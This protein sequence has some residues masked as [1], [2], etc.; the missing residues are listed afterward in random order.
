MRFR[1]FGIMYLQIP[2][3]ILLYIILFSS[4]AI[5]TWRPDSFLHTTSNPFHNLTKWEL[6]FKVVANGE[7]YREDGGH[8]RI[9][10]KANILKSM[11]IHG[12][13]R[14]LGIYE[15]GVDVVNA[16]QTMQLYGSNS[17]EK[18]NGQ[19]FNFQV[20]KYGDGRIRS[21]YL[22]QFIVSVQMQD[23]IDGNYILNVSSSLSDCARLRT[24]GDWADKTRWQESSVPISSDSV[25]FPIGS[26]VINLSVNLRIDSVTVNDATLVSHNSRCP[27]GWSISNIE[28]PSYKCY[29]LFENAT[30]FEDASTQCR[31][32]GL[33]SIDS[34]LVLI[35]SYAELDMMKGLCRGNSSDVA[36]ITGCWIGLR[37]LDGDRKF[38]W[39]E[40]ALRKKNLQLLVVEEMTSTSFTFYDWKRNGFD[41]RTVSEGY[42][43]G[44][45]KCAYLRSWQEDPLIQE[46]GSIDDI[47]CNLQKA[48]ICQS[49]ALTTKFLVEAQTVKLNGGEFVGGSMSVSSSATISKFRFKSSSSLILKDTSGKGSSLNRIDSLE[50]LDGSKLSSY[51]DLTLSGKAFIG[52]PVRS[53]MQSL[54]Y[55]AADSTLKI[56]VSAIVNARVDV[57]GTLNVL[58]NAQITLNQGGELSQSTLSLPSATST[59]ALGG[60]AS[61]LS[62]YDAYD[63]MLAHRGPVVGEYYR[64][65]KNVG[66]DKVSLIT[67]EKSSPM[68]GVYKLAVTGKDYV[69]KQEV[70]QTTL[71]IDYHATQD[72]LAFALEKLSLISSRGGVTVRRVGYADDPLFSYGYKHRIELDATPSW[73]FPLGS[74]AFNFSCYGA[75]NC[76]CAESIVPM[77]DSTGA[78]KCPYIK[79]PLPGYYDHANTENSGEVCILPPLITISKIS[80][81][82][83]VKTSG[84]GIISV[85]AGVHRLPPDCTV[86]IKA[87]GGRA[88]V[89]ANIITWKSLNISAVGKLVVAGTGWLAWDSSSMLYLPEWTDQRAVSAL[90]NA[91]PAQMSVTDFSVGGYSSF[92]ISCPSTNVSVTNGNW[93]GGILRGRGTIYFSS[94]LIAS[95]GWKSLQDYILLFIKPSANL[96]W[97]GGNISIANGAYVIVEG[98]FNVK[99]NDQNVIMYFGQSQLMDIPKA[100]SDVHP[101]LDGM[102]QMYPARNWNGYYDQSLAP[103]I[104]GGWY[105]NPEC[106]PHCLDTSQILVRKNA[107]IICKDSVSATFF[108]PVN[109]IDNTK[110]KIGKNS[111]VSL[112]SGGTCDM[113]VIINIDTGTN[114]FLTGGQFRM[115][116]T[117][118]I[119]GSGELTS[120]AGEHTLAQN[121]NAHIT[122][123]GGTLIWPN[124]GGVNKTIYFHGG[125]LLEKTGSLQVR[126]WSTSIIV[127]KVV[128]FRDQCKIQFPVIGIAAQPSMSDRFDAPDDSPR[129]KLVAV[130]MLKFFGGTL[131]GKADFISRDKLYLGGQ[132]KY[133]MSMAKLINYGL[134]VWDTGNIITEN[135]GDFL[136]LGQIKMANGMDFRASDL[137]QGTII[138]KENGGDAFAL[139]FHS[140]DSDEGSLDYREYVDLRRRFVSRAPDN[141][142][143]LRTEL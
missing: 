62:T 114:I 105:P 73:A 35:D 68:K 61:R 15:N 94:E 24:V 67:R 3:I 100:M 59:V 2:V 78:R 40:S 37:D 89:A 7:V 33:G 127:D 11:Q 27:S 131:T 129:G 107:E 12:S 21:S 26:G 22:S 91:P 98:I 112:A 87:T 132:T 103:E 134:A 117:C 81:L 17:N 126:P 9:H 77:V 80:S 19:Y 65:A 58:N 20:K 84:Q 85:S 29:K 82:S 51:T 79:R 72:D 122:I 36:F 95:D 104:R 99:N 46:E 5:L 83:E 56:P 69:T 18:I 124:E 66:N 93:A 60:Y 10:L 49:R 50:L 125:L 92:L 34:R 90:N 48:Y 25:I 71:C 28:N 38:E 109:L 6:S 101:E 45:E 53:S 14:C 43:S 41:N 55:I 137:V 108:V 106:H 96:I 86:A 39:E 1:H 16:L 140:Y 74:L 88:I 75:E 54:L 70:T 142:V 118:T 130:K 64:D 110:L 102:L 32:S 52:E 113:K 121:I 57:F 42:M 141:A 4:A 120:V 135:Q 23:S 139:N 143:E 123:A 63:L 76:N 30:S 119:K 97:T 44:G 133:I 13:S 8:F 115:L 116:T 138:P 47:S 128:E 136:N 31:N 111:N